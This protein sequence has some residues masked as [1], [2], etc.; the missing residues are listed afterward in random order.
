[1]SIS[2]TNASE[3][4]HRDPIVDVAFQHLKDAK[5]PEVPISFHVRELAP[6]TH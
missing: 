5:V 4:E 6:R 3:D 1:M 2:K